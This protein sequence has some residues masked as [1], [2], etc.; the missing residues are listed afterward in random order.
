[1]E[2]H[3][4]FIYQQYTPTLDRWQ[5]FFRSVPYRTVNL[6][7]L[8]TDLFVVLKVNVELERKEGNFSHR[9]NLQTSTAGYDDYCSEYLIRL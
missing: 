7:S 3:S 8:S 5:L 4:S 1:M 9:Y 6:R 2:L